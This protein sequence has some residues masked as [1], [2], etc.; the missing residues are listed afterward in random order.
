MAIRYPKINDIIIAHDDNLKKEDE[1]GILNFNFLLS[2]LYFIKNHRVI[3]DRKRNIVEKSSIL[4]R[5]IILNHPFMDGNKRAAVASL[6]TFLKLNGYDLKVDNLE[7]ITFTVETAKGNK[8]LEDI[9]NFIESYLKYT[10][11]KDKYGKKCS[12]KGSKNKR[13]KGS[14]KNRKGKV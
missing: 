10:Y 12:K 13:F 3:G 1:Q 8:G 11:S 2:T 6:I 14:R 5:D 7:L 4:Y 9:Q